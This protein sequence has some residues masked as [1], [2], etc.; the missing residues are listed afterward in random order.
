LQKSF[1]H[2]HLPLHLPLSHPRELSQNVAAWKLVYTNKSP[3]IQPS[4]EQKL[5][6]FLFHRQPPFKH[7]LS[8][9]IETHPKKATTTTSPNLKT[10]HL[11]QPPQS[12]TTTLLPPQHTHRTKSTMMR[13][14]HPP[15][16]HRIPTNSH[17]TK[18]PLGLRLRR[19]WTRSGFVKSL[20]RCG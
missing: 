7:A 9:S 11:K 10:Y 19:R 8:A 17:L 2:S 14:H 6:P 16:K 1:F 18:P 20:G 12:P 4:R 5:H 15:S 13:P 3:K